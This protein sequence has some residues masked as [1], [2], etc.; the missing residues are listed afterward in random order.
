MDYY[1]SEFQERELNEK[2]M[3]K[4]RERQ[5]QIRTP[6]GFGFQKNQK[7]I[8]IPELDRIFIIENEKVYLGQVD[9]KNICPQGY[10]M[11]GRSYG[12]D[13]MFMSKVQEFVKRHKKYM[14]IFSISGRYDGTH[15]YCGGQ[16]I[17]PARMI[18]DF[19][20]LILEDEEKYISQF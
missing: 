19:E 14:V 20:E 13:Y 5:D 4:V 17:Y 9:N 16:G 7:S 3:V 1:T 8:Y 12:I 2:Y 15:K 11:G 10:V 6:I 18:A